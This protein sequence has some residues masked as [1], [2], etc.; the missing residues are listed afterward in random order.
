MAENF[1]SK[2]SLTNSHIFSQ[3]PSG[4]SREGQQIVTDAS[5]M[6]R[7]TGGGSSAACSTASSGTADGGAGNLARRATDA[8]LP[9]LPARRSRR[10]GA[11]GDLTRLAGTDGAVENGPGFVSARRWR[12]ARVEAESLSCD[13]LKESCPE[14]VCK[15]FQDDSGIEG[16]RP[17]RLE[18]L[19]GLQ[20]VR[21]S[22][23][24]SVAA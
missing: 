15:R 11:P 20:Q 2:G 10:R 22:V 4:R 9:T 17:R 19:A 23:V 6:S 3:M 1:T 13:E 21:W 24:E 18:G 14:S 12:R 5:T 8:A 16:T 7:P